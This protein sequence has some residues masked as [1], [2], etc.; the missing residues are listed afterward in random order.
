MQLRNFDT[1]LDARIPR[2]KYELG[3]ENIPSFSAIDPTPIPP[4]CS[5]SPPN[6]VPFLFPFSDSRPGEITPIH[7]LLSTLR[8]SRAP[9]GSLVRS[10]HRVSISRTAAVA[11]RHSTVPLCQSYF[12]WLLGEKKKRR[13]GR[14][15][16]V[17]QAEEGKEGESDI[18]RLIRTK[19]RHF[20]SMTRR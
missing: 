20:A 7:R 5:R 12:A 18:A 10:I 11:E 4:L 14:A 1:R 6:R 15:D 13:V 9:F 3:S 17:E 2:K 19:D 16:R 8:Y